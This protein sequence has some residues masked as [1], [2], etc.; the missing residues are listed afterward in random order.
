[1]KFWRGKINV[2]EQSRALL[3]LEGWNKREERENISGMKV[4]F[5][6]LIR[7]RFYSGAGWQTD[8]SN[9]EPQFLAFVDFSLVLIFLQMVE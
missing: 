4:L 3:K 6:I 1:M 2:R 7:S 8:S 9:K 5:D